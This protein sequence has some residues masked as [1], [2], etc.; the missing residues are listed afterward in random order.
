M[1]R[2][3]GGGSIR[4]AIDAQLGSRQVSR[5]ISGSIIGLALVLV[6]DAHPT[7]TGVVIASLLATAL[8]VALAEL[9]SDIFFGWLRADRDYYGR[10]L[11]D[12]NAEAEVEQMFPDSMAAYG[13]MCGWTL[14]HAPARTRERVAI[15]AYLSGSDSFDRAILAFAHSYADQNERDYQALQAAANSERIVADAGL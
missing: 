14:A 1:T 12:W 4:H 10:Q 8:A 11:K 9:Y 13:R 2:A 15:A 6:L 3:R 5:V 7:S